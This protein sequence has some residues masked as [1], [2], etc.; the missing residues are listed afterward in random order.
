MMNQKPLHYDGS[1]PLDYE[2]TNDS[3]STDAYEMTDEL[4]KNLGANPY[5]FNVTE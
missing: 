1:L 3:T 5:I 4:R 2:A